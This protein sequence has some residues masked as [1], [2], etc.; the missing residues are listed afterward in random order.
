MPDQPG[1][2]D[3]PEEWRV[4]KSD[5]TPDPEPEQVAAPPPPPPHVPYGGAQTFS[6]TTFTTTRTSGG[7]K[8][9]L[10]MII[11]AVIGVG[12]AATI[13]IIAAVGSGGLGGIDAKDPDDFQKLIDKLEKDKGTTVV[14]QVGFYTDYDIVYLPYT[15]DPTDNRQISYTWRGHSFEEWTRGTSDDPTFDLKDIDPQ[16]ISGMCD[17]V[18]KLAGS[19]SPDDCYIFLAKPSDG[20]RTWFRTSAS[21]D[22]NRSYWVDY[23]ID[24]TEV[25]RGHS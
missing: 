15:K 4:Y 9:I 22:F 1:Q 6:T 16:V 14:Q 7:P 5:P 11:L 3:P 18:L 13:A 21:D 24:G 25:D 20:D 12:V 23:D 10:I 8:L 2:P 19:H 17:P